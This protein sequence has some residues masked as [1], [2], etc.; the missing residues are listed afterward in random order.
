MYI[1]QFVSITFELEDVILLIFSFFLEPVEFS[2]NGCQEPFRVVSVSDCIVALVGQTGLGFNEI[3]KVS[4]QLGHL[5]ILVFGLM[6]LLFQPCKYSSVFLDK[7][8]QVF[9]QLYL[10]FA[11][12]QVAGLE[13]LDFF[14]FLE[15]FYLNLLEIDLDQLCLFL[16]G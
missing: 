4:L 14:I 16:A 10:L 2:L 6:L 3:S 15:L 8:A 5:T 1:L 9:G 7:F 13:M 11:S 12:C